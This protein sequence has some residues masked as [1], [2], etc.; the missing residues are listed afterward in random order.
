MVVQHNMSAMNAN[1]MFNVSTSTLS[2]STEKLSSGYR[3]NRAA[4]DAAG[5]SISEKMRSQ[6]RGLNQASTNAQDGIS[7]IQTAE[8]ALN[9]SH[10]ILQRMR[11]LSVQASNGTETDEDREAVQSEIEQLQSE[12][13]R[14][15]ETTEFNTMKLLDGSLGSK[16]ASSIGSTLTG[17][18]VGVFKAATM[19]SDD[20]KAT[21]FS[22]LKASSVKDNFEIDGQK[23]TVDWSK[24]DAK[25]FAAKYGTDFSNANMTKEQTKALAA[26]L[27][28]VLNN[29]AADAGVKGTV[30]VEA[31][32]AGVLKFTSDNTGSSSSFGFLGTDASTVAAD[33]TTPAATDS[34]GATLMGT[35]TTNSAK[36]QDAEMKFNNTVANNSNF[37]M[38]INGTEV[39]ATITTEINETTK[40]SG[41]GGA[42]E[43]LQTAV[44][45]AVDAY[46]TAM[47][48]TNADAEF[49]TKADF[50]V[51]A[52]K[53]GSLSVKYGGSVENVDF[54]FGE[55]TS[56]GDTT[57]TATKLGLVN[58]QSAAATQNKGIKLQIG[59]NEGQTMEF[60]IDDMSAAAL[61]VDG[62]KVN[63]SEQDSASEATTTI[64][65]AIK[66]V[67]AQRSQLGAVQNRLEHTISNLDTAAENTQT[68]ESR[69]R[70]TDMAEE[71]VNYSKTNI[72]SQAGQ[73]MLAQANQSN[74]GVLSLLQ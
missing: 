49:L 46:N 19:D 51:E 9:E 42:A 17:S 24:G 54:S 36:K 20:I 25:D 59:A 73:S 67:S 65:A 61:G 5:L 55:Y 34:W 43:T 60:T 14:I 45:N 8:G 3:I 37:T 50:T 13:T 38:T 31:K 29:A 1:R 47:G 12:L 28:N 32:A 16:S 18:S 66:K 15:S 6:I 7:L 57:T 69:I 4:D 44:Q 23:F 22:T 72:L 26:D 35:S 58:K 74:Q 71:M 10:S 52:N 21:N 56:G 39:K 68:A 41:T 62:K 11:E 40:L 53:D 64:D 30:K 2:K 33:K 27:Q 70:D 48:Y 63:L